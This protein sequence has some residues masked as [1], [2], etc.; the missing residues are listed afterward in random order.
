MYVCMYV[1]LLYQIYFHMT[2]VPIINQ[3]NR[4]ILSLLNTDAINYTMNGDLKFMY[5]CSYYFVLE[6]TVVVAA[7][8]DEVRY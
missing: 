7:V 4:Y 1:Q 5:V 2:S 3:T 6:S 8:A